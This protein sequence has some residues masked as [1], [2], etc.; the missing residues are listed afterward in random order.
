MYD[1]SVL[2]T[3]YGTFAKNR[4]YLI[5]KVWY[6]IILDGGHKI[7]N[8]DAQI[9]PTVKEIHTPHKVILSG[10]LLQN[11]LRELWSLID[12]VYPGRLG[13]LKSFMDKFS[14]PI[15]PIATEVQVRTTYKCA[16]ILRD[17]INLKTLEKEC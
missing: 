8:P 12:F 9:T 6:Y 15:T 7:R 16:C 1:G 11:S 14:I 17:A 3:S 10:S 4:K 13:A 5:D 2:L